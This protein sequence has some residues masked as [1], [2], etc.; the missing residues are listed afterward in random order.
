MSVRWPD[1]EL[2]RP[3]NSDLLPLSPLSRAR[4]RDQMTAALRNLRP[5]VAHLDDNGPDAAIIDALA[6][7]IQVMG[8]Y[9]D[10]FLTES[11][12]G[13]AQLIDDLGKIVALIGYRPLPAVAATAIQFFEAITAGIV[14]AHTQVAAAVTGAP[15]PVVFETTTRIEVS[16]DHN[17]MALSPLITRSPGALRA[18]ITQPDG[19]VLPTDDFRPATLAMIADAQGL[20]L[21]PVAG[22]RSR[23]VAFGSALT[24]SY[25][26]A[27]TA[28]ARTTVLRHLRF[29]RT[30]A[31]DLAAFEVSEAPILHLPSVA[32]PEVLTST[33]EIFVLRPGDD[34]RDP[35]EWDP[36]LRYR[37]VADFSASEASDL[38]YRTFVDDA[39]HTWVVL[40]TALGA[41]PL[42][43]A[44]QLTR[45]YARLAPAV[46]SVLPLA[47]PAAATVPQVWGPSPLPDLSGATLGL[48]PSYF[49][50]SLVLPAVADHPVVASATWAMADRDLGLVAGD[51]ILIQDASG[52]SV[53]TLIERPPGGSPR[54]LRWALDGAT[55]TSAAASPGLPN[56]HDP[57][58]TV[59][60]PGSAKIGSLADAAAGDP[61]PTWSE[62]YAQ[63]P[64][65]TPVVRASDLPIRPARPTATINQQRV[66]AAGTTYLVVADASHIAAG[67]FL[68][69]GRRLTEA[70]RA[71]SPSGDWRWT[72]SEP[73]F[74]P[75]T[76]WLGAEVVQAIEIR[77]NVV[78]LAT[79]VSQDYFVDHGHIGTTT[80]ALSE[81]AVLPGVGSVASGDQLRQLLTLS[82]QSL[83]KTRQGGALLE[84]AYRVA[85]LDHMPTADAL[86]RPLLDGGATGAQALWDALFLAVAGAVEAQTDA[87]WEFDIVVRCNQLRAPADQITRLEDGDGTPLTTGPIADALA[88]ELKLRLASA[89][90]ARRVASAPDHG[91][92]A[93]LASGPV[94]TPAT[95]NPPDATQFW[96]L[97]QTSFDLVVSAPAADRQLVG[98]AATL[99]LVPGSPASPASPASG[100]AIVLPAT[101]D[102]AGHA[103]RVKGQVPVVAEP[104]EAILVSSQGADLAALTADDAVADWTIPAARLLDPRFAALPAGT[105]VAATAAGDLIADCRFEPAGGEVALHDVRVA[106]NVDPLAGATAAWAVV[107]RQFEQ[108][109]ALARWVYT[110]DGPALPPSQ[111]VRLALIGDRHEIVEAETS[112]DGRTA[113]VD[114]APGVRDR[115]LGFEL[116]VVC[117]LAGEPL[118][119]ARIAESTIWTWRGIEPPL[120]DLPEAADSRFIAVL[121]SPGGE[122]RTLQWR[123]DE[124]WWDPERRTLRLPTTPL[125]AMLDAR[126][127]DLVRLLHLLA[128]TIDRRDLAI[129][130]DLTTDRSIVT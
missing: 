80:V 127:S 45:V 76:P 70:L 11:K 64:P 112:A 23:G 1:L 113:T 122:P 93:V 50:S 58:T 87:I 75:R 7:C 108:L 106:S 91:V 17:R 62:F 123:R 29:P 84:T 109:T 119:G 9:H 34:A 100:D 110:V 13:S 12:L 55:P 81:L 94:W 118:P 115:D 86:R 68:L 72:S 22:S 51:S 14:E 6:A 27:S 124:V 40:R 38:H 60:D 95:G 46:G 54:L 111:T 114:P 18:I 24:R 32:A 74:D 69:L 39:L 120:A 41:Q 49:T 2:L 97:D 59:L 77:G 48:E 128:P 85:T 79:P 83:F 19:S 102:G 28:I 63:L 82:T 33:L 57:I 89:D 101:W 15:L 92:V 31:A 3:R 129:H 90:A 5:A 25:E 44:D 96:I 73:A 99:I 43:D 66:V 4:A 53:R 130:H 121:A 61:L 71:P 78:R 26:Q 117:V 107:T 36:T 126:P 35:S 37:E 42:L 65:R 20:E 125:D 10:R 30:L 56:A 16:P 103:P 88:S 52:S 104:F 67:D 105:L 8:F 116:D 47:P 98:E 21:A